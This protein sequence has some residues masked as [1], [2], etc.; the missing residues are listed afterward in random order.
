MNSNYIPN[1]LKSFLL[2]IVF[3]G[4]IGLI[5]S[6]TVSDTTKT[7]NLPEVNVIGYHPKITEIEQLPDING[8]YLVAGKKTEVI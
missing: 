2:L 4:S 5:K 8:T 3:I 1:F 6:Q 7:H